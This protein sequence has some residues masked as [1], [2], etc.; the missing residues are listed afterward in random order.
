MIALGLTVG[1]SAAFPVSRVLERVVE[2]MQPGG[3]AT[4]ALVIPVLLA[5][6]LAAS[7]VPAIRASRLDPLTALRHE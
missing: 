7:A 1:L 4:Y 6:A 5:A 3:I 2:G